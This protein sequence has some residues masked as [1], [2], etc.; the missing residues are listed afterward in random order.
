MIK[1]IFQSKFVFFFTAALA[2][3]LLVSCGGNGEKQP[4]GGNDKKAVK[5]TVIKIGLIGPLTGDIAAMGQGMKNGATLAIEQA[6][7]RPEAKEKNIEFRLFPVDDRGD[8][9]EAVNGA[10]QLISDPNV[11]GVVGHL[12]SGCSIPASQV[13]AK[14]DMVMISPASTNPKLTLQGLPNVFRVCTTDNVQGSFAADYLYNDQQ[15]RN[16]AVIHDKTPYGQGLAEE[17]QK[18]FEADGGKILSFNGVQLG[19]KDFKA[20]LTRIKGSKPEIIYFGGMYQ[21]GG[22]MIKQAK[23]L[24]I[25]GILMGGDGIFSPEFIKVGGAATE[26]TL[27]SMIGAPPELIPSAQAFI[28]SYKTKYPNTAFQP[29]D[30]YTYDATAMIVDAVLNVGKDRKA[31]VDYIRNVNYSGVI[32]DTKFDENGDTLNKIIT[33][34]IV[35]EGN[36]VPMD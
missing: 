7:E 19:D 16:V 31:I 21:E 5:K 18:R 3:S 2:I 33:I 30:A 28:E 10:N 9:K 24:G 35:K 15:V 25:T 12:N 20:L 32:G 4:A 29:Y 22:L 17:F 36:F 23:E 1:N 8:P 6:N 14:K 13:Y 34:Y 11:M 27:A 26:G